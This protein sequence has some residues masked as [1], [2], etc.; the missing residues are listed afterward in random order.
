MMRTSKTIIVGIIMLLSLATA[1]ATTTAREKQSEPIDA[2]TRT[3]NAT[4]PSTPA[5][6]TDL[7]PV[8]DLHVTHGR[9]A[10]STTTSLA[11]DDPTVR[12]VLQARTAPNIE[13]RFTYRGPIA[14]GT[15]TALGSGDSTRVQIGAKLR[16]AD[17]CNVVYAMLRI[18]PEPAIVVQVKRN[19]DAHTHDDCSN[20]G[21]RTVKPDFRAS[22]PAITPGSSHRLHASLEETQL[23]VWL[24]D[25][26]VWRGDVGNEVLS[27]DG[28]V[29]FRTDNGRFDLTILQPRWAS[30]R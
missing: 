20:G 12:G 7:V 24:D 4:L 30:Q 26:I 3:S 2:S 11:I 5:T 15:R 9:L 13:L 6:P 1:C 21:Y 16:A 17:G 25:A 10:S 14:L 29:G 23:K 18:E 28:P 22:V 27:F 8:T 19:P